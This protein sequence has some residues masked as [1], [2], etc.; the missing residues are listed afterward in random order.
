LTTQY[1]CPQCR[2]NL[3]SQADAFFCSSCARAYSVRNGLSDFS[4]RSHYW[5]Q[6][7]A[8]QMAVLLEIAQIQGYRYAIERIL[9][10]LTDKSLIGYVLDES[11]ADFRAILP[12]T[13][14][15]DVLDI[16]GGWGA[17]PAA[18]APA[19]RSV[20]TVDTNPHTLEFI[21]IRAEQSG[22]HNLYPVRIDP[23][24]DAQL[25]FADGSFD[26]A[27][28]NGVLEWV[29]EASHGTPPEEVQRRC[30]EEV[31]RVLKPGGAIYVGI[32][33]RYALG[34]F[35]GAKDHSRLRYTSVLPRPL[36]NVVMR[37]RQGKPYRTYTYSYR[38]YKNLLQSAGFNLPE[39]Y[40]AIPS[41][42]D[43]EYILPAEDDR[44]IT[45]FMRRRASHIVDRA[46]RRV[47][48]TLFNR[49]PVG[50]SCGL[51][52]QLFYSYLLVAEAGK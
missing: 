43:P 35:M 48:E 23:L 41:Y 4:T 27:V 29:G 32:E 45:Y 51:V 9:S 17:V 49:V 3:A 34:Y 42:R 24:D 21:R 18:L 22:L 37:F 1:V 31:R 52:R 30:L 6:I 12:V 44:A 25:P 20:T 38:G 10:M 47:V 2:G 14:Q 28:M 36:A 50:L 46:R 33:N 19:C 26:V 11:R 7:T 13:P 40:L 15:S 39:L 8:D 16:G 5:N